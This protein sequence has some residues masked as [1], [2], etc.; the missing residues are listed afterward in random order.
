MVMFRHINFIG[1][2]DYSINTGNTKVLYYDTIS[3]SIG[4]SGT[5]ADEAIEG[6]EILE[7]KLYTTGCDP[8]EAWG[9]RECIF[10]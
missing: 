4:Y 8:T 6:F 7:D 2:G 3:N 5:I 9:I 10:I 1:L